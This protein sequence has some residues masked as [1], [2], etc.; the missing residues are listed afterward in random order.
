MAGMALTA[1][2]VAMTTYSR[3]KRGHVSKR[4]CQFHRSGCPR[5]D[6]LLSA[7][8]K[9]FLTAVHAIYRNDLFGVRIESDQRRPADRTIGP[10]G[11]KIILA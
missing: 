2:G 10:Q 4:E 1:I 9:Q 11:R 7:Q 6:R 5:A 8:N 3:D